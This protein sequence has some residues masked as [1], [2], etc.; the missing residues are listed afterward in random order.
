[1]IPRTPPA[2]LGG[3]LR[4]LATALLL[5]AP[6][7]SACGAASDAAPAQCLAPSPVPADAPVTRLGV[8]LVAGGAPLLPGREVALSS[9]ARVTA[10]KA[11]LFVADVALVSD[12]GE[13][14]AAELVDE[15]GARLPYG[16]TL[17]DLERPE[18]LGLSL[19]APAG[20]Y[21]A[22]SL[23]LGVP[24]RCA[25]GAPLNHADASAMAAPLDVDSDMYWSWSPGYVFLKF[26]GQVATGGGREGFFYHVGG[27]ERLAAL[28]L[29]QE[30]TIA[31]EGGAGPEL[32]ADFDRLLTGPAGEA[33]PDVSDPQQRRVHGGE[34]ADALAD[35]IRRS[36]F[37]R[38][39]PGHR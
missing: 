1:M 13:R 33:R 9:G 35:N 19:K 21:R 4:A 38:L 12:A 20:R 10:S 17:L 29:P 24:A 7:L 25:S 18:S 34:W 11:R 30:L 6:A 36:G 5:A 15:A 32:I 37:L 39:S 26:E 31:P 22:L 16:L 23:S 28:E 27:D 2:P 8:H 3:R 14:V